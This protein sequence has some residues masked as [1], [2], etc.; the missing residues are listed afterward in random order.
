M[1]FDDRNISNKY[2]KSW[3]FTGRFCI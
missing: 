1:E 3:L 2:K